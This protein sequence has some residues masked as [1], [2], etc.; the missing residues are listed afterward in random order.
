M[1]LDGTEPEVIREI[2]E[3]YIY[4]KLY[5]GKELLASLMIYTG[6]TGMQ[7]GYNPR[8]IEDKLLCMIP[9]LE[10]EYRRCTDRKDEV[11]TIQQEMTPEESYQNII[12]KLD[13]KKST[14]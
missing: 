8:V 9:E 11:V 6:V 7:N 12:R 4:A 14:Q 1:V 10:D 2:G 13:M 3:K 5:K